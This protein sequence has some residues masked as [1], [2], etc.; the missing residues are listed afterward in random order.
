MPSTI[1]PSIGVAALALDAVAAAR[2]PGPPALDLEVVELVVLRLLRA[3]L[4]LGTPCTT[5][6]RPRATPLGSTRWTSRV[7]SRPS[8]RAV[9]GLVGLGE[10]LGDVAHLVGRTAAPGRG[11][12]RSC[13]RGSPNSAAACRAAATASTAPASERRR[14]RRRPMTVVSSSCTR[15]RGVSARVIARRRRGVAVG[16]RDRA[17]EPDRDA[18]LGLGHRLPARGGERG[19]PEVA[20]RRVAVLRRL[21]ERARH[22]AV[23]A[24]RRARLRRPRD[25]VLEVGEQR[26]GH[27][28]RGYGGLPS[29][30]AC[31][32]QPSE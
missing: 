25:R 14:R 32:T 21:G 29:S 6:A 3:E 20:R 22:H 2:A 31:S 4:R 28:A 10:V 30:A 26:R 23:E 1:R 13:R 9:L 24:R 8:A 7:S 16:V 5:R 18:A 27:V 15:V 19:A 12:C 17:A 11:R